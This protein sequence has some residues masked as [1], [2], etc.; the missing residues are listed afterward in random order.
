[1]NKYIYSIIA[2]FMATWCW[3]QMYVSQAEY[4]WD[5]DPGTGNGTPVLANDGSFNSAFEQLTK[6]GVTTPG[7][8]LHKLSV[9]I[10]DNTGVWGPVFTN[11]IDVQ[12]NPTSTL[13]TISQAEYF[14]DTDP[15]VG[16][17]TPVLAA[18][19]NF[20]SAYE[21]LTKTGIALPAVGLHVFNVRVKD[22]TGVWGAVF[23]NVINVETPITPSGCWQSISSGGEYSLG[24][25]ADGTL[26]AWGSNSN[27]QLGD[28]T[29]VDRK[30]PIQIGTGNNW[31]KIDTKDYYTV[32][33]KT[34]G[35]LW[36]WGKN[37]NGQL[38]DGTE[39]DKYIP[40][41]IGTATNWQSMSAGSNHTLAIK[42]DGTLWGWGGNFYG[43]LGNGTTIDT[44]VPTQIGTAT[45]W[46]SITSGIFHTV[47][48]KTDGT[49]WA[50]GN[51]VYGQLGDGTTTNKKVPTQIGNAANW[52]SVDAGDHYS[53][54]LR[55]DGTLWTWGINY[56]GQLGDGTTTQKDSPIQIGTATNWQ[57]T[58]AGNRFA[59]ATRTNGT[60]WSWGDNA[61]GQLGNGTSGAVNT[62]SPTQVGSSSDNML[63]SAGG[64]HVL[65]KNI[66]GFLKV[67]GQNIFGQLGDGTNSQR[68]TFAYTGCPSNCTAP[69]QFSATN[70]TSST[71]V[72]NWT[73]SASA[74]N[75]GYLYLYS[76]SPI[77][78]GIDGTSLST[79]ANLTN[80][81]PGTK[82]F[83]W[84]ASHCVTSQGN[85]ISGGSFTT[86]AA[87][88]TAC[89]Q[90]VSAGEKH[91]LGIKTDGTLWAWGY[92]SYGQLG[93]GTRS[94]KNSPIQIGKENNWLQISGGDF[95]SIALKTNGTLWAWGAN[96]Y[97]QLGN[98]TNTD[99]TIPTQIG[100]ATDWVSITSGNNYVVALKADGTIWAWG[101][102]N[103]GQLADGTNTDKNTPTQIGTA[104]DWKMIA[105]GAMSTL[106]IKTNGTLW[107]WG[108][109]TYGQLGNGTA[110]HSSTPIQVGTA[111]NWK[112]VSV[113]HLHSLGIKTDGTLWAW[114]NGGSGRLG[115][116]N[117]Y[118]SFYTPL[119]IGT[120]TDW[121]S[122]SAEQS[123]SSAGIKTD[124]TLWAWG[125][126]D[127]GQLGDGTTTNRI[128]PTQIGTATDTKIITANLY[129]RWTINTNGLLSGTGLNDKGQ[130][131]DGT[132]IQRKVFTPL[133]CPTSAVLRVDDVSTKA[134]QLIVYPNPVQDHLTVSFDQKILL[135][136]VY[137]ASGQLVLTK[138]INDTKGTVDVSA[139]PSGVYLVKINAANDYV[140]TVKVIKR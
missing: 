36:T 24:I 64:H 26:W 67:C 47:A 119:K 75:G 19:G 21:Q 27:G 133:A 110:N 81:L 89:W 74:P 137:N 116:G 25:K 127:N 31:L 45:N 68:N 108:Y 91:S 4:F 16:N 122:V 85:W 5:N 118:N 63:I 29:T 121:Q 107:A 129:N 60:L 30:V 56:N 76:T 33:I 58:A 123:N 44:T 72:I 106:A 20:N 65:V 66:D 40:T 109:N 83:W 3:A 131:G 38:G 17:G 71:A 51:N 79:T 125:E 134:D 78:G 11:V 97:G 39:V 1:M 35:T 102:N 57:S 61:D 77:T 28:G 22:N 126:N 2:L 42:T 113:G 105:S 53:M 52:K 8:G 103:F 111:T 98:G 139:L 23:K 55:T 41:Q 138:A 37:H 99:K 48:I 7:N 10:K 70:I 94:T 93:D 96:Y 49:L 54:G 69:T 84:V 136:T 34:D 82:Y 101:N 9:R 117:I 87:T 140:K 15:G 73:A 115:N 112:T 92:N 132:N 100:T 95:H 114:G 86:L 88:G 59:F 124:G 130:I 13:M 80:L 62:T 120:A 128:Y 12:Q 14:W 18:D 32:A 90:S 104:N 135:V 43:Q 50:W 6:T 46:Q